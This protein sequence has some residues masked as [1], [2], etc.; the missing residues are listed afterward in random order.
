MSEHLSINH[1]F[2]Q[3]LGEGSQIEKIEVN[4]PT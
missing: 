3:N 2:C 4:I 1:F